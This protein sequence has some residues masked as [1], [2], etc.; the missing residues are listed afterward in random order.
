[1]PTGVRVH[2]FHPPRVC[3]DIPQ[4]ADTRGMK[5]IGRHIARGAAILVVAGLIPL[6]AATP[7]LAA[8][9][10]QKSIRIDSPSIVDPGT[11]T[12]KL[13]FTISW[14]GSKGG[15]APSVHY[16]TANGTAIAGRDY[17]TTTGTTPSMNGLCRCAY[18]NVPIIGD[19]LYE[20]TQTFSVNLSNAVNGTIAVARGVG[21]IYD[22]DGPPAFVVTDVS[23]LD[24]AGTLTFDVLLTHGI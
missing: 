12:A 10:N 7:A 15:P 2:P 8:R 13:K 19:M 23:A 21:T 18:V 24:D 4:P 6:V 16:A 3:S 22:N 17:T 14:S 20:G 9:P 11:G 5:H 1:M